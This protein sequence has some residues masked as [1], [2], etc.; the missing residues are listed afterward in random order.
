M[1]GGPL[2]R[3]ASGT[4]D[5]GWAMIDELAEDLRSSTFAE[6]PWARLTSVA[7]PRRLQAGD[8]LFHQGAPA[9]SLY[10]LVSGSLE[11]VDED[12]EGE[13]LRVL[14]RGDAV[15]EL[16]LLTESVRSAGVRARR[17]T[18]LLKV[19]RE[20]F[21]RL[22]NEQPDFALAIARH[23]GRLLQTARPATPA[24]D[25]LARVV[26]V[27]P[28]AADVDAAG[29]ARSLAE[30]LRT[31]G[32]VGEL[33]EPDSA[34]AGSDEAFGRLLNEYERKHE[35]VIVVAGPPGDGRAWTEFTARTADRTVLIAADGM[36]LPQGATREKVRG[37]DLVLLAGASR[38][39]HLRTWVEALDPR[40]INVA[41]TDA[42]R[43]AVVERL[44]RRMAGRSVGIVLSGGG[45]RGFAHIGVVDEL[46][47]AGVPIDRFGGTSMGAYVAATFAAGRSASEVQ[48]RCRAEFVQ[49][50]PL[51][52]YTVPVYG[53][54]R[55]RK[56]RAML[57]RTFGDT[58]IEDLPY[59]FFCISCDLVAAATVVHDRG[60]LRS[61]LGASMC[62]PA[63]FPPIPYEGALLVDGGVLDNL[64]VGEMAR[65]GEGPVIAV[66]VT[67]QFAPPARRTG[68][69]TR[70]SRMS[71]RSRELLTGWDSTPVPNV[72]ETLIRSM[73]L[74]SL[75][76]AG[77]AERGADLLIA[78]ETGP[79]P[80]TA[81]KRIDELVE[82]GRAAARQ[83][84]ER[85][86]A[87]L[88]SGSTGAPTA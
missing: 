84:L 20:A 53:V 13:V 88:R 34:G 81:F 16:A 56:A 17:D 25:P 51:S 31:S 45:A 23:L 71:D 64:P 29:F 61:A 39:P 82:A 79:I 70:R 5:L 44:A 60:P 62:L 24:V 58:R 42:E 7:E 37:C 33:A 54:L 74:G 11:V 10:V 14:G 6:S 2:Q 9:D 49:R 78:P 86:P 46:L 8:W 19:T 73:L 80:L 67:A 1:A 36:A 3:R 87:G 43:G 47:R 26:S 22:L 68:A 77:A 18:Y 85:A 55:S 12:T 4:F 65:R 72:K 38:R 69:P 21:E 27:L 63:I 15:G 32:A 59:E 35:H 83:A 28:L 57:E 40:S 66:D 41:H 50:N 30:A 75:D 48:R 76:P 52:D